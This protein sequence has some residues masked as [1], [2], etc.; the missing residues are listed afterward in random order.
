MKSGGDLLKTHEKYMLAYNLQKYYIILMRK[1]RAGLGSKQYL[2]DKFPG[3]KWN[4]YITTPDFKKQIN[5][6]E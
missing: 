2:N 3:L 6:A 4:E 5:D 1:Y